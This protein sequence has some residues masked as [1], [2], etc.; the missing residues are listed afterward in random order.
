MN[1]G[2]TT[3]RVLFA[4][5]QLLTGR[6]M[7]PGERLDPALLAQRLNASRTPVRE[8][9]H[10]LTGEG[11]VESRAGG[12]FNLPFLDASSLQDCY[13]WSAQ[14]L[15]LAVRNWPRRHRDVPPL[16]PI[17]GTDPIAE[18]VARLFLHMGRLSRNAEHARE[19]GRLNARLHHVRLAEEAIIERLDEELAA[20]TAIISSDDRPEILRTIANYHRRRKNIAAK[21]VKSAYQ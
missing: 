17:T 12:G 6:D 2:T 20:L 8:A 1:A 11:L 10:L 9:L 16:P 14:A 19:I 13:E 4:L 5:R 3:E 21:I 15:A 7:R 18:R